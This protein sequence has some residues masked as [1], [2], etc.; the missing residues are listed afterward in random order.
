MSNNQN[1]STSSDK[2]I[3]MRRSKETAR[4]DREREI[5]PQS[6]VRQSPRDL[7]EKP[8][9]NDDLNVMQLDVVD[10]VVFKTAGKCENVLNN[11]T[12]ENL[13]DLCS[14]PLPLD[15][16]DLVHKDEL[17]EW[18]NGQLSANKV[19]VTDMF[20]DFR[21]GHN[22]I[23]LIEVL[24]HEKLVRIPLRAAYMSSEFRHILLILYLNIPLLSS[25]LS[26]TARR[27]SRDATHYRMSKRLSTA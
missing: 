16:R 8:W 13:K 27:A 7:K 2:A 12:D 1:C 9:T 6:V 15:K 10:R 17:T 5:R 14:A 23:T 19:C 20:Q 22:L 26:R 24:A 4:R 21:D 25:R 11:D 3:K 18:I